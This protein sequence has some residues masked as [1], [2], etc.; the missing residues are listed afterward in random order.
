MEY[1]VS[2]GQHFFMA[3]G[4]AKAS[5]DKYRKKWPHHQA[6]V[7]AFGNLRKIEKYRALGFSEPELEHKVPGY[8]D[9]NAD[10]RVHVPTPVEARTILVSEHNE[11]A[12]LHTSLNNQQVNLNF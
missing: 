12:D 11:V 9:L 6:E 7:Y 8:C 3:V 10:E 1:K 2:G 4:L 5:S